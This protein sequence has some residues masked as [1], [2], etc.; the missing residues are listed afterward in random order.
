[1][2]IFFCLLF[3]FCGFTQIGYDEGTSWHYGFETYIIPGILTSYFPQILTIEGDTLINGEIFQKIVKNKDSH[4]WDIQTPFSV[5]YIRKKDNKV[6][7]FNQQNGNI[8]I[9][10]DFAAEPGD[11]WTISINECE[12]IIKVDSVSYS[13]YNGIIKKNLFV[14]D[15]FYSEYYGNVTGFGFTGKII[16]DIG[17]SV[18]FFPQRIYY[19]CDG[20]EVDG[21]MPN[22]I[23]C[24]TDN[25]F[26]N[27]FKGYSCDTTWNKNVGIYDYDKTKIIVYPNPVSEVLTIEISNKT[28]MIVTDMIG[29]VIA[30][31]Q[32]CSTKT[33]FDTST[34]KTGV[35]FVN[36]YSNG[37]KMKTEKVIKY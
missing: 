28:D 19:L 15:Y 23:R 7:W 25:G 32:N 12:L 30:K 31:K 21:I 22:G 24:Y 2:L 5:E 35:Y 4:K 33:Y 8:S 26:Y 17:H 37:A 11:S 13:N 16:E 34:W 3:Y 18:T 10:Y 1:M 6:F 29:R 20:I 14:K 36:I 27:N 9:L